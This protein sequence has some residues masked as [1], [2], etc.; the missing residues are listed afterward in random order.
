MA[1]LLVMVR[2]RVVA[3]HGAHS[4]A[5]VAAAR[6]RPQAIPQPPPRAARVVLYVRRARLV[7]VEAL[8]KNVSRRASGVIA[9]LGSV[10]ARL[11]V[12]R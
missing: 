6:A 10:A 7:P 9:E 3:R 8:E 11:G 12:W 2:V 1:V 4:L 5:P